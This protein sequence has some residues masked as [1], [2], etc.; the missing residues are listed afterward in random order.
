MLGLSIIKIC[1][2][3]HELV[4]V[5]NQAIANIRPISPIRLYRMA[6][7][8]AVFA[9]ARPCHHPINKNDIMPTPSQ[10]MNSWNR[11]LAVVRMIIVIKNVNRY[12]MNRSRFGSECM[13]HVENSMI[14][15]VTYRATGKKTIEKKSNFRLRESLID[16]I[17]IH[18]QFVIMSS[19]PELKNEDKGTRLM[20]NADL[21]HEVT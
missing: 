20:K 2:S 14:D 12:L 13:Y 15:H 21:I 17:V 1:W 9:S 5:Q 3:S 7:R 6:C 16:P 19:A 10:P 11:L 8:A 4:F 18:C